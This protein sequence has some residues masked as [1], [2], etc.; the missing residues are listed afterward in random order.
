MGM[1][2][3]DG[4]LRS[5][6]RV[7][8]EP[9]Y[10]VQHKPN[11]LPLAIR[12][13][14][15]QQIRVFSPYEEVSKRLRS[16][17][18]LVRQALFPGYVFVHFDPENVRWRAVNSTFGISRIVTFGQDYPLA[19][20]RGLIP[21]LHARCDASGRLL[22]PMILAPGEN[23]RVTQGAFADFVATVE[24]MAPQQRVWVLLDLMGR[25]TRVVMDVDC[26]QRVHAA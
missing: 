7:L 1:G 3:P 4:L 20:P 23:V 2:T 22:P 12:N 18:R 13:L 14:E 11:A 10:V 25:T 8:E 24:K 15:R 6:A 16:K 21:T 9:W 26:L 19:V 5:D 17:T